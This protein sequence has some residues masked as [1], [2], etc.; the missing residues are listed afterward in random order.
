MQKIG[1]GSGSFNI[2]V[3]WPRMKHRNNLTG[4]WARAVPAEI[5]SHWLTG[6]VYP[7]IIASSNPSTMA[8][9]NYTLDEWIWKAGNNKRFN[10]SKTTPVDSLKLDDMQKAMRH[11]IKENYDDLGMFESSFLVTELPH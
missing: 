4:K 2:S 6:V 11:I 8:Y 1:D 3:F 7:S 10:K 9:V 5:Q